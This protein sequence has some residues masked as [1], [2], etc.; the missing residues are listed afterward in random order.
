MLMVIACSMNN[1]T[2]GEVKPG[3]KPRY[4]SIIDQY[5]GLSDIDL[6]IIPF[7]HLHKLY[8]HNRITLPDLIV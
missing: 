8:R 6:L 1:L 2:S 4:M 3:K 7:L 5:R